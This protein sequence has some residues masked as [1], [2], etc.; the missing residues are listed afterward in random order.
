M[1]PTAI[2]VTRYLRLRAGRLN[3]APTETGCPLAAAVPST[4]EAVTACSLQS[5]GAALPSNGIVLKRCVTW[6]YMSMK[7]L[8]LPYVKNK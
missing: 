2:R 5:E 6:K 7:G 3:S 1:I 4:N 8:C